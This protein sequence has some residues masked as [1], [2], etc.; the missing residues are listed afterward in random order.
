MSNITKL[1]TWFEIPVT[2]VKKSIAFYNEVFGIEME[3]LELDNKKFGV[4]PSEPA[5]TGGAIVEAEGYV[6]SKDGKNIFFEAGGL[7]DEILARVEPAGGRIV[8]D[9]YF[10]NEDIGHVAYFSDLDGNKI[11]LHSL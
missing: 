7:L 5:A 6:P 11:G 10:V 1:I 3:Y 9:K 8:T 2:D 4:F